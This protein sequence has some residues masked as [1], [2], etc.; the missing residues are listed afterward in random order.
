MA[1]LLPMPPQPETL[2]QFGVQAPG[3]QASRLPGFQ[4]SRLP[5]FQASRL[6]GFQASRLPGFQASRLPGFQASRLPGFQASRLPGFQ[7][8]RLPGF[9]A[10]RLPGF[11]ASRLPGFQAS[12]LP[13]LGFGKAPL[14]FLTWREKPRHTASRVCLV[15]V[16]GHEPS[17]DLPSSPRWKFTPLP[18]EVSAQTELDARRYTIE[19][20]EHP[21]T[22]KSQAQAPSLNAL[23]GCESKSQ[24]KSPEHGYT[25]AE[26]LALCA[27]RHGHCTVRDRL[28]RRQ[29]LAKLRRALGVCASGMLGGVIWGHGPPS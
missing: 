2:G 20:L 12:R 10:S 18:P 14:E 1:V 11:Q 24:T 15:R 23:D 9:Q 5:G 21:K 3:F 26:S 4:A 22:P 8:S 25:A 29:C 19:L 13:G 28:H 7:A 17:V 6:P 16:Q 27:T